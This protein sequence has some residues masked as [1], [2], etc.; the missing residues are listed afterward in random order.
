MNH[1]PPWNAVANVLFRVYLRCRRLLPR[2]KAETFGLRSTTECPKIGRI[3]VINLDRQPARWAGIER[4]L[5]RSLDS[6][7]APLWD[8]TERYSAVDARNLAEHPQEGSQIDPAYT[9]GDQLFVEPQPLALPTSFDLVSPIQM[10]RAEIAVAQSHI[11]VWQLVA[12][13]EDEYSLILEDDVWFRPYFSSHLDQAWREL[14]ERDDQNRGF[15]ILYLSYEEVKHGAPKTFISENVFRPVRGLWNL[16][17]YVVSRDGARRLLQRLPCRGPIDLW[18]NH[19]F[20]HLEVRATRRAII[21][22]RPDFISTNSY[23]VLPALT[24]I[25][26]ITSEA[27]SL[28]HIRPNARPV[29]A[30]GPEQSGLTS[31]AMALSMLGY[32][33]CSDLESIPDSEHGALLAG[34]DERVFDAYVNIKSLEAELPELVERYPHAKVIFTSCHGSADMVEQASFIN[35]ADI[36]ILPLE[37]PDKWRRLCEHVRSAPPDCSFPQLSDCGHRHIHHRTSKAD[38]ST[39]CH[40]PARDDSPWI[41]KQRKSWF[42][43]QCIPA[44][45]PAHAGPPVATTD[46]LESL[47]AQLWK[48]REDTFTDNLALFRPANVAFPAGGGATLTV[49]RES[50]G[51]RDYSAASFSSRRRYMF[52]RFEASIKVAKVPGIISGFFLHRDSP[53]QEIDIEITGQ[54]TDR[55]VANVFY[56]PGTEGAKYDYGYRGAATYIDLGFDASE[57][58]HRFA[59]EWGPC[60]IRWYVDDVLVHSRVEWDP[61]PIPHL[62]MTLHLNTWPSRSSEFAGRLS[63][64][65][66]PA[67][68]F[69]NLIAIK[70]E[71]VSHHDNPR[72]GAAAVPDVS[73]AHSCDW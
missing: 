70:A 39:T 54:R 66:L 11:N 41:A 1:A 44:Q 71:C 5:R 63:S 30:F 42:G 58:F 51:V 49:R 15:D 52:G 19:Q 53:R 22:Q 72:A 24:R 12:E 28:F 27:A 33:C 59:I 32:R 13:R 55:L 18:L 23:S 64:R 62:P 35:G 17:G 34:S 6:T 7:G 40:I 47:D 2:R 25:G 14:A 31:L 61:T 65:L 56:N 60:D 48:L 38:V 45:Q 20:Q 57:S 37:A 29:F 9:L 8:C 46:C 50:L 67:T 43:I 21:S 4:E 36:A 3:Y 69:A 10:S 73:S 68:T 26:V 16:S